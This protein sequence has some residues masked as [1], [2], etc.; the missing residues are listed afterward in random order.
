MLAYFHLPASAVQKMTDNIQIAKKA[1]GL[2]AEED[3][4]LGMRRERNV[5]K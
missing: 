2:R 3:V 5:V 1:F 4:V